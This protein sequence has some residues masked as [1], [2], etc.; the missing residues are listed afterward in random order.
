MTDQELVAA[1]SV[2]RDQY[3]AEFHMAAGA[4]LGNRG[5]RLA[6]FKNQV[7]IR[8]SEGEQKNGTIEEALGAFEGAYGP[9]DILSFTNCVEETLVFQP[10]PNAWAGHYA[11]RGEYRFSFILGASQ[12]GRELLKTFLEL[13]DWSGRI[14]ETFDISEWDILLDSSSA[15]HILIIARLL[16]SES[17]PAMINNSRLFCFSALRQDHCHGLPFKI[18]VPQRSL[19]DARRVMDGLEQKLA[20][21]RREAQQRS[22]E[23]DR[24]AELSVLTEL[25]AL[26]PNE[27]W[28]HYRK[29]ILLLEMGHPEA[30]ADAFI[31]ALI[32]HRGHEELF[33][34]AYQGLRETAGKLPENIHILHNLATFSA[35][36]DH[37]PQWVES[38]Y[39]RII[40]L[41]PEDAM[42]HLHLGYH[43]YEQG[44]DI[45]AHR[46]LT[47]YL[48]LEPESEDREAIDGIL[49]QLRSIT[50][51][52]EDLSTD[53]RGV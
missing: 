9:F 31:A 40:A 34:A 5:I 46:H 18:M 49:A 47:R 51:G 14:S 37:D 4:E 24:Q 42:A 3:T 13:D 52:D 12:G 45:S 15:D 50:P 16:S 36:G 25:T 11:D 43:Y 10:G 7:T 19:G 28:G 17:I 2:D 35:A 6:E 29:G 38:C 53:G 48:E 27:P 21:L 8:I 33:R 1:L 30:A 23:G 41:R 20:E 39:R 22:R 44:D 26:A 32:H